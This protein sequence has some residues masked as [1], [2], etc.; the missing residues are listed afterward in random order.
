LTQSKATAEYLEQKKGLRPYVLSRSNFPGIG[1]YAHHS[2]SDK[3][4]DIKQMSLSV[5]SL[6]NY[7]LFGMPFMGT[8]VC[9]F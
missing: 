5:D 2:V 7:Q 8:D 9:G 3:I 4:L 6:Y 1:K